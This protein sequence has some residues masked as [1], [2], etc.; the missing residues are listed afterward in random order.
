MRHPFAANTIIAFLLA[1]PSAFAADAAPRFINLRD[2][3]PARLLPAPPVDGSLA[4][5]SE[6]AEV[7]AIEAAR[8]PKELERAKHDDETESA[9]I[10]ADVLG[11]AFD[12]AKLPASAKMFAD[13]R[14]DEKLAANAAKSHF[15]RNRPWVVDAALKPCSNHDAPQSSFPSGHATMG[16]AFAVVLAEIVP[17]KSKDLLARASEYAENRL[18][19][20]MHFRRDIVAGEVLGTAIALEMLHNPAFRGEVDASA[21]ELHA[22]RIAAQ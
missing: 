18:V 14:N 2:F 11:P 8:T 3:D 17:E 13:I 9:S 6:L 16:F 4:A 22:I 12:L 1:A 21:K 7:K 20:G 10:F 5:K 15:K 19:C